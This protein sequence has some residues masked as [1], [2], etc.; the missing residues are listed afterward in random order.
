LDHLDEDVAADIVQDLKPTQAEEV[1]PLLAGREFV[2]ELLVYPED[3]AGG[4]MSVDF[5]ALQRRWTVEEAIGFLRM[6]SPD[7]THPFYLYVVDD[8][9]RLIGTVS[10]RSLVTAAPETPIAALTREEVLSVRVTE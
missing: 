2:E 5:V 1:L 6:E 10:L 7:D 9:G 3:S 8:E 4:R